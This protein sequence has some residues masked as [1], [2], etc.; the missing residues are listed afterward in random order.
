M[1]LAVAGLA[2]AAALVLA[3]APV[4]R[5]CASF[6]GLRHVAALAILAVLGG[7]VYGG[8]VI[9]MF[10]SRWIAGLRRRR[11]RAAL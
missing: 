2:L 6:G 7:L 4:I 10:G 9:A 1:K 11:A 5:M 3:A 8:A